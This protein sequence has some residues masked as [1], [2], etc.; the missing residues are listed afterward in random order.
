MK[1]SLWLSIVQRDVP[2][3]PSFTVIPFNRHHFQ[4]DYANKIEES[5]ITLGVKTYNRPTLK[6]I[7]KKIGTAEE[8]IGGEAIKKHPDINQL[9]MSG[10]T[11][12]AVTIEE[13]MEFSEIK[14]EYIITS[15]IISK[16]IKIIRNGTGEILASFKASLRTPTTGETK[17]YKFNKMIRDAL[18]ALGI[19]VKDLPPLPAYNRSNSTYPRA[20]Q[21]TGN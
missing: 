2:S 12:E 3:S 13:Y 7:T 4:I 8:N 6:D 1:A 18:V 15:D 9:L 11:E 21:K 20:K 10:K 17:E 14:A 5:L 16:R 19:S